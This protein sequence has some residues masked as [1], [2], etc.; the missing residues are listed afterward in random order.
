MTSSEYSFGMFRISLT[1]VHTLFHCSK[2][3]SSSVVE[4]LYDMITFCSL[5]TITTSYRS[6]NQYLKKES[7]FSLINVETDFSFQIGLKEYIILYDH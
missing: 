2:S 7:N 4:R 5:N 6:N 3:D 1:C